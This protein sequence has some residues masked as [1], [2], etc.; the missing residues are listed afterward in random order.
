MANVDITIKIDSN[1]R[2]IEF[3]LL[4]DKNLKP[5]N[6]FSFKNGE[7]VGN[8]N[9]FPLGSDN[10]LDF[11]IVTIGNPNSNS[12]M[13]VIISGIEKGSFNLFKPFNRNGYG[14]FNQEIRL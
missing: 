4:E 10:D 2:R 5:Q 11:L 8:F 6:H 13:K 1:S 7:W 9:N 14:Q 12:K 3:C